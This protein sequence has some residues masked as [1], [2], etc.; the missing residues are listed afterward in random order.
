VSDPVVT[1]AR[2]A[3]A[4]AP[5]VLGLWAAQPSGST[6][7]P[8]L[9]AMRAL[10]A[11]RAGGLPGSIE[12]VPLGDGP[13][14]LRISH[15]AGATRRVLLVGHYDTV[16]TDEHPGPPVGNP[17]PEVL[18]G[19]GVADMKGGILVLLA[20]LAGLEACPDA[21]RLGWEVL[22]TPDEELGAP[23]SLGTLRAAARA[24]DM[25]L[26]FEPAAGDGDIVVAR[27]GREVLELTVTGRAAHA[28]R[29]PWEGRSAVGALAELTL[30]AEALSSRDDGVW[31][32]VGLVSGGGAVNV[33]PASARAIVDVRAPTADALDA[34][35]TGLAEAAAR[36]GARREV[37]GHVTRLMACPPMPRTPGA[38]AL[39]RAYFEGADRLGLTV[40]AVEVGGVSDANHLAA[41]GIPVLDGLG[42]IGGGLH[43]PDEW[44]H[45]PSIA[46]R[47]A[48][49]ALLLSG[50]AA[51]A[52]A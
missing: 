15:R 24:A 40:G 31:V 32:N 14:A 45:L 51:S 25:A 46:E 7:L 20:A 12:E 30:A 8:G 9:A 3:A 1:A 21:A 50:L 4:D 16:H 42:V 29:N 23:A 2:T 39:A 5:A 47:A 22:L 36:L 26:V 19:P 28:G 18:T 6:D 49:A 11:E 10:I 33:V 43:G 38:L 35:R 34:I 41:E 48:A 44:V 13:P 17:R 37:A 52:C 27:R